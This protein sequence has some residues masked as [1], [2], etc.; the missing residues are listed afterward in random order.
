MN[1]VAP[2]MNIFRC[3]PLFCGGR[4]P[5]QIP[6]LRYAYGTTGGSLEFAI[7]IG[8]GVRKQ[9]VPPLRYAPVGMTNLFGNLSFGMTH[10]FEN[11]SFGMTNLFGNLSFGMTFGMTDLFGKRRFGIKK[12]SL[13]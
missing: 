2:V 6:P 7:E 12:L 13:K 8:E 1:P 5:L 10:L 3:V 11:Q 4:V 9:Q